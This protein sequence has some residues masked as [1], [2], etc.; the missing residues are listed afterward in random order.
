V[1]LLIIAGTAQLPALRSDPDVETVL[2]VKDSV[3]GVTA[4]V[5]RAGDRLIKVNNYYS[6]GGSASLE[7]ERNQALLPLMVH[8]DPRKVFFLGMGTGIT[9]GAAVQPPVERLVVAELLPD[10]ISA[11]RRHFGE[12]T[13]GLFDDPRVE[14][15]SADGRNH[16]AGMRDRYDLVIADLFVP[17]EAGTGSL[18]TREHFQTV[19]DRLTEDGVFVQW[20]PLYQLSWREFTVIARTLLDVFPHVTLW[21][22][23]FFPDR[24]I[25]ALVGSTRLIPLVPETIAARGREIARGEVSPEAVR[26]VTLPFYG[27]HLSLAPQLLEAGALN[28]DDRPIVE[29]VAPITQREQRTGGASWLVGLELIAFMRAL[30][31]AVPPERDPYLSQLDR[32]GREWVRAG[33]HYHAAAVHR[34]L[35]SDE[36]A[37]HMREFEAR[38]APQFRLP[39]QP[40]PADR[41]AEWERTAGR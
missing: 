20:L 9:A 16:L 29:Y 19:R 23:D 26:A 15:V 40:E 11:A 1:L 25:L 3:Y 12:F 22:G 34:R 33:F 14:I 36:A 8:P 13:N 35:Q 5:E 37:H 6:L 30:L 38:I 31:D 21:R 7:H 18:Y 2:E 17:W 39:Q 4:V 10:V 41:F 27:G 28:T 32:T 24:P